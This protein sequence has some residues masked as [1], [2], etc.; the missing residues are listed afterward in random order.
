MDHFEHNLTFKIGHLSNILHKTTKVDSV[1][2]FSSL[3]TAINLFN[4]QSNMFLSHK[5]L[6]FQLIDNQSHFSS[7]TLIINEPL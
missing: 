7:V 1:N 3:G 5:R 2:I 4:E 6:D